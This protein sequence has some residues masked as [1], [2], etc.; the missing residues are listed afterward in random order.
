VSKILKFQRTL[1]H[2]VAKK[3]K[4]RLKE[5]EEAK[6]YMIKFLTIF[7]ISLIASYIIYYFLLKQTVLTPLK[8]FTAILLSLSLKAIGL[9][10]RT[11]SQFVSVDGFALEIIDECT[12]VFSMLVYVSAIIAYPSKKEM[13]MLGILFGIAAIYLFN[14]L[15]LIVLT[16]T[17]IKLPNAFEFVH[18]YL[19]QGTFL[20]IVVFIF[21][22]WILAVERYGG[23]FKISR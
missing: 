5:R 16:I 17:G 1:K 13:K 21:Y 2:L 10:A 23:S 12:G 22:A 7:T 9:H 19:W 4:R 15:R 14:I 8:K 20:A 18:S 3:R 6:K 11:H